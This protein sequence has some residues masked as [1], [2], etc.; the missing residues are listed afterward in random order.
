MSDRRYDANNAEDMQAF[1]AEV[2]DALKPA[3]VPLLGVGHRAIWELVEQH[4]NVELPTFVRVELRLDGP[5]VSI[6]QEDPSGTTRVIWTGPVPQI[7]A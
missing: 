3:R 4:G 7:I 5:F 2:T 6:E 1:D